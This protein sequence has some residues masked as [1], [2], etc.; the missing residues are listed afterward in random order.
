[1]VY[2]KPS[3]SKLNRST[4]GFPIDKRIE[5]SGKQST[6]DFKSGSKLLWPLKSLVIWSS[7]M[8][9]MPPILSCEKLGNLKLNFEEESVDLKLCNLNLVINSGIK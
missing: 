7:G 9:E 5:Y 3:I 6:F 2:L 1:M 4:V 8:L